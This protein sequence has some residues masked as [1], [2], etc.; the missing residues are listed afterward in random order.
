MARATLTD[1][2]YSVS[3]KLVIGS[4][5]AGHRFRLIAQHHDPN[6]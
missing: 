5:P 2:T 1:A 3:R 4:G 6:I